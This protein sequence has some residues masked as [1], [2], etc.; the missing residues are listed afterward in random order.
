MGVSNTISPTAETIQDKEMAFRG[1]RFTISFYSS[2]FGVCLTLSGFGRPLA[3][4]KLSHVTLL[5]WREK[6]KEMVYIYV[7]EKEIIARLV[8][9]TLPAG[10]KKYVLGECLRVIWH[11]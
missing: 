10:P 9:A 8:V 2:T 3:P 4:Y 7:V 6:V 5:P 11:E 1:G